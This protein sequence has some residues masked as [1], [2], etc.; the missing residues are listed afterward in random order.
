MSAR[1]AGAGC[2]GGRVRACVRASG[3]DGASAPI[4][5]LRPLL[6]PPTPI[7]RAPGRARVR[8]R[9]GFPARRRSRRQQSGG[10]PPCTFQQVCAYTYAHTCKHVH[11]HV[12]TRMHT[13]RVRTSAGGAGPP[14]PRGKHTRATRAASCRRPKRARR[15][16]RSVAS[17][18]PRARPRTV[19]GRCILLCCTAHA[20]SDGLARPLARRARGGARARGTASRPETHPHS[21]IV[22]CDMRRVCV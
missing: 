10:H 8:A 3:T 16:P 9:A 4:P 5:R 7:P 6:S 15:S 13:S 11:T 22:S 21:S 18:L 14:K 12:C 19:L 20:W 1:L 17:A 2:V